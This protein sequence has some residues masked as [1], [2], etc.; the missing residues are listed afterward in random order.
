[1]THY[2]LK[3][4]HKDTVETIRTERENATADGRSLHNE[5]VHNLYPSNSMMVIIARGF[6]ITGLGGV[7]NAYKPVDGK[8]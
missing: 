2:K 6:C 1:M 4:V 8:P 7:R 5:E 3:D